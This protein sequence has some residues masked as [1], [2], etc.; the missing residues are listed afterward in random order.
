MAGSAAQGVPND[1]LHAGACAS[2]YAAVSCLPDVSALAPS[3][4]VGG[5]AL[6]E[7][8]HHAAAASPS[9]FLPAHAQ[10][11]MVSAA[12]AVAQHRIAAAP[13][14]RRPAYGAPPQSAPPPLRTALA[15]P[16]QPPVK[17]SHYAVSEQ[18]QLSA[19]AGKVPLTQ[20]EYAAAAKA[21]KPPKATTVLVTPIAAKSE[22]KGSGKAEWGCKRCSFLNP[23]H[24]RFCEICNHDRAGGEH[25]HG[26]EDGWKSASAV[27]AHGSGSSDLQ[28]AK[29]RASAKNEKRRA[30]RA[31]GGN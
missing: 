11:P 25:E 26:N 3:L 2:G 5:H 15:Q 9:S 23:H 21:W 28:P 10:R 13:D 19:A 6:A 27:K 17:A 18:Q 12:A 30:K 22:A 16:P 24:A 31:N 8:Y 29:S 1:F 14:P 20:D 4:G 7:P